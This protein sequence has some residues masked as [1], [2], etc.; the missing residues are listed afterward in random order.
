MFKSIYKI[1]SDGFA[2]QEIRVTPKRATRANVADP[3]TF[4]FSTL[5]EAISKVETESIRRSNALGIN[6]YWQVWDDQGN[7]IING[8]V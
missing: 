5:D 6:V 7:L 3:G 8:V 1:K 4:W 2:C